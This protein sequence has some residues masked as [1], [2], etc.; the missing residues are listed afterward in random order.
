MMREVLFVANIGRTN[1][2]LSGL[3]QAGEDA[4]CVAFSR[5]L[6]RVVELA[7]D[8]EATHIPVERV[9]AVPREGAAKI[10]PGNSRAHQRWKPQLG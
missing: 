2:A 5:K 7:N 3:E 1:T 4:L 6:N 10:S 8:L 9:H